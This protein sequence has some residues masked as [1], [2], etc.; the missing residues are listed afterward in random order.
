MSPDEKDDAHLDYERL[1]RLGLGE[2]K[3]RRRSNRQLQ[4]F[5][6]RCIVIPKPDEGMTYVW[7]IPVDALQV[8]SV[9]AFTSH[10]ED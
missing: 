1:W 6:L 4:T 10:V 8:S 2:P 9:L 5:L 7:L 3:G